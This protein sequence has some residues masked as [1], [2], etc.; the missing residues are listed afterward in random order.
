MPPM[1]AARPHRSRCPMPDTLPS[2]DI[3]VVREAR[4]QR[5]MAAV[6][7]VRHAVFVVE[8]GVTHAADNDPNDRVSRHVVGLVDGRIVGVGRLHVTGYEGQI[9]WVAVLPAYRRRGVG[10]AV[11]ERLIE[12]AEAAG[13]GVIVLNAQTHARRFYERLGFHAVGAPFM[14]GG[15]EHQLMTRPVGAGG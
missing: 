9:A 2:S 3:V 13:V 11:M 1:I 7:A 8:Q 14:M 5:D 12:L 6:I 4:D 10:Q 15:I